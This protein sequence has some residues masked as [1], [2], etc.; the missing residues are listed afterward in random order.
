MDL[1]R[2]TNGEKL[3][4]YCS[5]A[6]VVLSFVPLWASY[7]FEP[8]GGLEG[9][10]TSQSFNAW[11]GAYNFLVKL[12]ILCALVAVGLVIGKAAGASLSLPPATYLGLGGAATLFLLIGILTGPEDGGI[13]AFGEL[14][15]LDVSR[16]ILLF[17]G[18]ILAAGAA[19]G[20]YQHMQGL[21]GSTTTIGGRQAPPA[22]PA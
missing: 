15:G 18:L 13:G 8:I 2:L 21:P 9:I 19:Y 5:G 6:L 3:V 7:S 20:G 11:S 12:A 17:V 10:D 14:V 22:P 1:N 4:L 16:G